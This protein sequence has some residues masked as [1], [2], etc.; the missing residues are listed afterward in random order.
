MVE[1]ENLT[2]FLFEEGYLHLYDM[3]QLVLTH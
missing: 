2:L 3:N 1:I